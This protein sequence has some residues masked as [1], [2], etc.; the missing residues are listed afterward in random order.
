MAEGELVH[1]TL[2][3]YPKSARGGRRGEGAA[4]TTGPAVFLSETIPASGGEESE[5]K[6]QKPYH[7][8][9]SGGETLS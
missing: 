4:R 2:G 7:P 5:E 9:G 6:R 3:F 1:L 8:V